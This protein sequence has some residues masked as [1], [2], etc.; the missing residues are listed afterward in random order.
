[1]PFKADGHAK[2]L[3]DAGK[4]GPES[5]QR[6]PDNVSEHDQA[7]TFTNANS[8]K[9]MSSESQENSR[10]SARV[11]NQPKRAPKGSG[12]KLGTTESKAGQP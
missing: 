1:M 6:C 4:T 7:K 2:I 3:I 9:F 5:G 11:P 12:I 10:R 8:K